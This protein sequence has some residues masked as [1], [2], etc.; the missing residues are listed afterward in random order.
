LEKDP[1]LLHE[2]LVLR[3][4]IQPSSRPHHSQ[5]HFYI[6]FTSEWNWKK[7]YETVERGRDKGQKYLQQRQ[8][9]LENN[10]KKEYS[11]NEN[12]EY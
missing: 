1:E 6:L 8:K 11:K 9:N 7:I 5:G 10:I 12:K 2:I 4:S 3:R